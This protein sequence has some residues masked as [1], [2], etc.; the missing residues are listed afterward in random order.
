MSELQPHQQRVVD[1]KNELAER[2]QKL[3]VFVD[4]KKFNEVAE[5]ERSLLLEQ[6]HHMTAYYVTLTKRTDLWPPACSK[7]PNASLSGGRRPSA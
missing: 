7:R 5:P 2:L 6:M 3:L 4:S 1:E